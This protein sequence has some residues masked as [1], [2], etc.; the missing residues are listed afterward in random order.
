[1]ADYIQKGDVLDYT[2][3]GS[4]VAAGGVVVIGELVAVAP[5]PIAANSLGAVAVDGV[6]ALPCATGATG[7][8]GSAIKWVAASGIADAATGVAAGKLAKARAAADATV[9]VILNK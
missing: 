8:Q 6:F 4:A 2:A 3:G 7:A 1:M 9:H 5:R